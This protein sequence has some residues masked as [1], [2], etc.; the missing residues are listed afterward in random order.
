M[1]TFSLTSVAQDA[2]PAAA[3]D[4]VA[5]QG[6]DPVKGKELLMQ[7]VLHVISLMQRQQVHVRGIAAKHDM[8]WLYKWIHNSSE[9]INQGDAAAAVKVYEEKHCNDCFSSLSE[10]D[11]D[12]IIA[13]TSE[14]KAAAALPVAGCC[15]SWYLI[16]G[17]AQ[18]ILF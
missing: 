6:G 16:N 15:C 17:S 4:P 3:A 13:Y 11:I 18:I 12:N 8:P 7:I 14:P 1:L 5:A 9:L 10:G 2:V